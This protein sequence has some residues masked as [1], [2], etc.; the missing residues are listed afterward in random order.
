MNSSVDT[1][2]SD[3]QPVMVAG[4]VKKAMASVHA[5]SR[6]LWQVDIANLRVIKDFNVRVKDAAYEAHIR[7]LADSIKNNGFFQDKPIGGYVAN[8]DGEQV[9]YIHDG[10]CRLAAVQLAIKEGAQIERLPVV[11]APPGTTLEDL[12]VGLIQ[13]N[14]GKPLS[15][16]E[17]AVVCKRLSGFGWDSTEISKRVGF[18]PVY[19]DMLL[20]VMA[21]P[22]AIR[23]MI[24]QGR[25]AVNTALEALRKYGAGAVDQLLQAESAAKSSGKTKVTAK[26][27]PGKTFERLIKRSGPQLFE[28]AESVRH[29]PAFGKLKSETRDLLIKLLDELE[30]AKS[31]E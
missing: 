10:H 7:G 4:S 24:Q 1:I 9:I 13:A 28:A 17:L 14:A 22:L 20:Q 6:D 27:L 5:S 15:S 30:S 16:Y 26:H 3:F 21:A 19:I 25:V 11:V 23:E 31:L 8:E 18:T 12:T 29:D 2:K